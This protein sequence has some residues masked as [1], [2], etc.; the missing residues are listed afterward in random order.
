MFDKEAWLIAKIKSSLKK[1]AIK[2]S[3]FSPKNS[4]QTHVQLIDDKF[5]TGTVN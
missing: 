2:S 5:L 4:S 1:K 3:I